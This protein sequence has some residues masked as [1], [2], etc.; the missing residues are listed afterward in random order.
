M[1]ER[2]RETEE[3]FRIAAETSNDAVYE[4]DMQ[5]SVQWFGKIDE[6]LGYGP[7]EFPRTFDAWTDLVHPEDKKRVADA[8]QAYLDWRMPYDIEYRVRTKDGACRWWTARGAVARAPDGHPIRWIGTV[9]D[10][11]ERKKAEEALRD[12]EERHRVLFESS[13][14]AIMTLEPPTWNF[15][16]GNSATI[17]MFKAKNEEEFTSKGPENLSPERQPDGHSS[18][19]KAKEMIET[20]MRD[21]SNFFE[22]THKRINGEDFFA[23]VLLSRVAQGGKVFLQATVRDITMQKELEKKLK[24]KIDALELYK[25][26]TVNRELKMIELKNRMAELEEKLKGEM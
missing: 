7:G 25:K 5:H 13:R 9:T 15:T 11:T 3:R 26:L 4:W 19:E 22:W 21:G 10:I 6:M 16:T 23:T 8:V 18:A 2:L 24:E 17:E 20:A 12:S 1:E 14:D